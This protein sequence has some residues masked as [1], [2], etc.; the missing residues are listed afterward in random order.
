MIED[1]EDF[2]IVCGPELLFKENEIGELIKVLDIRHK[3]KRLVITRRK[4]T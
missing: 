4:K 2:S 3:R 1:V